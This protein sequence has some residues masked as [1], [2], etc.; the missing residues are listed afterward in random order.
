MKLLKILFTLLIISA[1]DT[2][3][4]KEIKLEY[5]F[6]I[7]DEYAWIQRTKYSIKQ[8]IMGL[9]QNT[10]N[11][12]SGS[13]ILKVISITSNG[14]KLEA[15]YRSITMLMNLPMGMQPIKFDSEGPQD[16]M[17]NK[18]IKAMTNKPFFLT[19]SKL[20]VVENIEGEENLWSDFD[21]LGLDENQL[22]NLKK[23]FE[24]N[25]GKGSIKSSFEMGLSSYPDKKIKMGDSWQNKTGTGLNYPV[26]SN[27]IW[28]LLSFDKDII[29]LEGSGVVTTIDK[30]QIIDIPMYNLKSKIDLSGTQK[31]TN[32]I[33]A[34]TG[35][36]SEVKILSTVK[37]N[38]TLMAGGM[39]PTDLDIPME[40]TSESIYKVI[41]K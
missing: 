12:I 16:Q 4:D 22:A 18:V 9:E 28:K 11:A 23:Q 25:F 21:E 14:A 3:P 17:E 38:M 8:E 1:F 30:D 35:W 7:G 24:Q 37:G 32:V 20:G 34:K 41:K 19:L 36:P 5:K 39:V 40:I 15:Q 10:E 27:N 31:T 33:D 26:Q 6:T 29:N 2:Y 13:V